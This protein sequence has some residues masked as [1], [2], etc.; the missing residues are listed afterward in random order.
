MKI[1]RLTYLAG[2]IAVV[3]GL[4]ACGGGGGG[5]SAASA[6]TVGTSSVGVITGFGSVFVNGVEFETTNSSIVIDGEPADESDLA[7]G[8]VVEVNGTDDGRHGSALRIASNDELEGLVL[9]NNIGAGSAT[10]TLDIMGQSVNVS[11]DTIF[12]SD[13]AGVA[14]VDQIANGNI[15]EVHGFSDGNGD[16]FATHLEVKAADL[17]AYLAGHPR[18][19]E[20][21]GVVSGL[22]TTTQTFTLGS[23]AVNYAGAAEVPAGLVDG[24]Y[25]EV[26]SVAGIDINGV[27][28]ASKVEVEDDGEAGYQGD[29]DEDFEIRGVISADFDGSGFVIDG[30]TVIVGDRTEMEHLDTSALLTGVTVE[31]EGSYDANG[32]LLA[33]KIQ[34]EDEPDQELDAVIQSVTVTDTNSGTI[35]LSGGAVITITSNTIMKDSRDFG[36]M[37]V[38]KF[39]LTFLAAGDYVE[40]DVF[41]NAA[42][43]LEAVKL[44]REDNS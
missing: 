5:D 40:V 2:T 16:I 18:G 26:K 31:V 7:V 25:V 3:L 20:V 9:A 42:G 6:A 37:P 15:V 17:A 38:E 32:D 12:E 10:G 30:V 39:N 1:N 44:E 43:E 13:V 41:T 4:S 34:R 21:K 8:M 36:M 28:V 27:L 24:L 11:T 35:T 23:M 29:E 33:S 14:G 19:I 22:D